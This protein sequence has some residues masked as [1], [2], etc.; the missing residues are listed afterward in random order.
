MHCRDRRAALRECVFR[1]L[2]E[3]VGATWHV[4][5]QPK[6]VNLDFPLE[7]DGEALIYLAF[8]VVEIYFESYLRNI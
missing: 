1:M 5:I 4:P 7:S 2:E 8:L 3:S 6:L